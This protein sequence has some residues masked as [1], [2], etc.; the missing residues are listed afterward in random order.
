MSVRIGT[1]GRRAKIEQGNLKT[2]KGFQEGC[3]DRELIGKRGSAPGST[4]PK[5]KL[6][7][8]K[9]R[10]PGVV[11]GKGRPENW[12]R[13]DLQTAF[14]RELQRITKKEKKRQKGLPAARLKGGL[15]SVDHYLALVKPIAFNRGKRKKAKRIE[16]KRGRV[17]RRGQRKGGGTK[18]KCNRAASWGDLDLINHE[19][20]IRGG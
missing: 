10:R 11:G 16:K 2:T 6:K 7:K 3:L 18:E 12:G 15:K 9:K 19:D 13:T 17:R 20:N 4:T 5:R 8:G 1:E 14:L